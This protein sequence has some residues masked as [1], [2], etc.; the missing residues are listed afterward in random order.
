MIPRFETPDF[1][2]FRSILRAGCGTVTVT[3][4]LEPALICLGRLTL[5]V[6]VLPRTLTVARA[7]V[8]WQLLPAE[9]LL[10]QLILS[11]AKLLDF[12]RLTGLPEFSLVI[13]GGVEV[14][15]V[16]P[17]GPVAPVSPVFP[18]TPVAPVRPV[19]PVAPVGPTGPVGPLAPVCP[20]APVAPVGPWGRS[21][22]VPES[23]I[24][25]AG[26]ALES[27]SRVALRAPWEVG[28]KRT[29]T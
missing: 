23:V 21:P 29:L 19:V 20:V 8:T 3:L 17:E 25:V 24:E 1:R 16:G 22:P 28:V 18:V 15:P 10:G 9:S 6:V 4:A 13:V 5:A 11:A 2:F 26:Y 14:G 27:I 12:A 7:W